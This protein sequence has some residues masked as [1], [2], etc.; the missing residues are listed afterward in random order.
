MI[1]MENKVI[2][3]V[4]GVNHSFCL[5]EHNA[6]YAWG[7]AGFG[8]L[9]LN[10]SPPKDVMVPT[11]LSGFTNRNNPAKMI[12]AGPTCGMAIDSRDSLLL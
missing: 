4:C 6:V 10:H 11:K 3:V 5:D 9:G 7:F 12:A 2:Q 8:R 1:E